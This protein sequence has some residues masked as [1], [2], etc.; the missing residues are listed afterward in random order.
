MISTREPGLPLLEEGRVALP[1][2]HHLQPW[3][4]AFLSQHFIRNCFLNVNHTAKWQEFYR[5]YLFTSH[6]HSTANALL[7]SRCHPSLHPL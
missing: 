3:T 6:P 5:E 7:F 4:A 2:L 1:A